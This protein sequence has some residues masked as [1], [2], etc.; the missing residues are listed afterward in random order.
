MKK[1]IIFLMLLLIIFSINQ[2]ALAKMTTV[3]EQKEEIPIYTRVGTQTTIQFIDSPIETISTGNDSYFKVKEVNENQITIYATPDAENTN[4]NITTKDESVYVFNLIKTNDREYYSWVWAKSKPDLNIKYYI[5]LA[6]KKRIAIDPAVR[7]L[8]NIYDI[9]KN[10]YALK[11]LKHNSKKIAMELTAKRAVTIQGDNMSIYWFRLRNSGDREI[12][13]NFP[14]I[15]VKNRTVLARAM[16]EKKEHI[17]KGEYLD[18]YLVLEGAY[19]KPELTLSMLVNNELGKF[20]LRNIPYKSQE[21][22]VYTTDGNNYKSVIIED[23]QR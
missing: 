20:N 1:K 10:I 4:L 14:S 8:V 15:K 9:N 6:N 12:N 7:D 23:Y 16:E 5:N 19:T 21:F 11:G 22:K 17:S 13:I 3:Y 18:L 2:L